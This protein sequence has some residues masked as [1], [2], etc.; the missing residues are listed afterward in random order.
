MKLKGCR[1][2]NQRLSCRCMY[3]RLPNISNPKH[4]QRQPAQILSLFQNI[5]NFSPIVQLPLMV[6]GLLIFETSRSHSDTPH[7]VGLL[8]TSDQ[9]GAETSTSQHTKLTS[10]R[11]V[12]GGIRTRNPRI[13]AAADP[14]R[15]PRGH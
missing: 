14:R 9:L 2:K 10:H 4:I 15:K 8:F 6:Q 5:V 13:Q 1:L 12:P 3:I 7:S 11:H